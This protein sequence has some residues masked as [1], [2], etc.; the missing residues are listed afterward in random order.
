[1]ATAAP[2]ELAP[3]RTRGK[4]P[5]MKEKDLRVVLLK[6]GLG[7]S[8]LNSRVLFYI[9]KENDTVTSLHSK[10]IYNYKN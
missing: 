9:T 6:G 7:S 2:A 10:L 4:R 1:M 5:K 3:E 8:S